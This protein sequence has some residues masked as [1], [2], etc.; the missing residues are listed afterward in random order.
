APPSTREEDRRMTTTAPAAPTTPEPTTARDEPPKPSLR[1]R[2]RRADGRLSPYLY[3]SP[4]FLLFGLVGL[5]PLLYTF[6]VSLQQWDLLKG[7]SGW[8]G[9]DMYLAVLSERFFWHL[10][11]SCVGI[12]VRAAV[13]QLIAALL[14]A[15]VLD[16][17]LKA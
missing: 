8:V 14:L 13:P 1:Q 7:S 15:A 5:F 10:I 12:F 6:A 9:F 16:Q 11:F 2:L 4:V 17:A 3:V